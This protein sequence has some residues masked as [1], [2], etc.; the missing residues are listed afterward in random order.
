[1][2]LIFEKSVKGRRGFRFGNSDVPVKAQ[3]LAKY[4]RKEE[5]PLP[6]P[7]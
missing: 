6:E 3:I 1:M 2:D 7:S 4:A 5:A